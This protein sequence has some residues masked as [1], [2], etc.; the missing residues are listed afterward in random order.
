MFVY[1][2]KLSGVRGLWIKNVRKLN[3]SIRKLL[4]FLQIREDRFSSKQLEDCL[5][6]SANPAN[7]VL[8]RLV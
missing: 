8:L 6:V 5:V 7:N 3:V 4:L 1:L 2:K